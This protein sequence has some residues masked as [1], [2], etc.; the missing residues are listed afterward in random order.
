MFLP[1]N[2]LNYDV[3][4][5]RTVN[6]ENK[7][8]YANEK[9][10]IPFLGIHKAIKYGNITY[11]FIAMDYVLKP[12][13]VHEIEVIFKDMSFDPRAKT[14]DEYCNFGLISG[15]SPNMQLE[16]CR[17]YALKIRDIVMNNSN[18]KPNHF[19]EHL[20]KDLKALMDQGD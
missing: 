14:K 12:E 16:A 1:T 8:F 6:Q 20:N 18:Y 11:D 7:I 19:V 15:F 13:A 17:E 2:P 3:P 5:F 4:E 10:A 9:K